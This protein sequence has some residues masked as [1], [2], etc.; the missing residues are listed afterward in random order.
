M[1]R[2]RLQLI[3]V[4]LALVAIAAL[5]LSQQPALQAVV[6]PPEPATGGV[7]A[8]GLIGSAGRFNP[9]LDIYNPVDRDVNRL[10]F[11]GLIRYDDRGIAQPDL[12]ESWGMSR[13]GTVYNFALRQNARWHDGTPVTSQ[14]IIFTIELMRDENFPLPGDIREIWNKVEVRLL[15]EHT[16]Q[17]R[18]PEP[19]APFLD[20]LTF[21]VLPYHLLGELTPAEIVNDPFNLNPV[22]TG[23][24]SFDSLIVEEGEIKGVILQAFGDYYQ[25]RAFLDEFIFRYYPDARAALAAY[26]AGEITGISQLPPEVLEQAL[27]LPEL[28]IYSSRLPELSLIL[29]NLD[30][31]SAPFLQEVE[32]RRALY[33]ALNR[34]Y[35]IDNILNGQAILATGPIYP[36]T[37]AVYEGQ[38]E[39]P[40]QPEEAV[41][42][43]R[44]TEY[45]IPV[46]GGSV[47]Q[48]EGQALSFEL[49]HP[50]TPF[51]TALA[52]AIQGYWQE[53]GVQV[54]LEAV[55]YDQLV[56]NYLEPR[57]Y[58]A[59]LV[60]FTT[61]NSP[62]PDPY[63]FWH[64]AQTP[65]GQNYSNWNDRQASE[66][67][68]AARVAVDFEER[69]RLYRNF[70]VRFS[71]ELPALPLFY[72]VYSFGVDN[73]V[74]GVRTGPLFDMS[75][76]FAH[77]TEWYLFVEQPGDGQTTGEIATPA[78]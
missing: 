17:I 77:V 8:E 32:V 21:G 12:A 50:D 20:L 19:Y 58:Q 65:N 14:D 71:Q 72:P 5:L 56:D 70:Q 26:E 6:A 76:R 35:M 73:Q 27:K 18:L 36:G 57:T 7:Y 9:L 46:E 22:G 38:V 66:Y 45:T 62:D 23:P 55:S 16:L 68:E 29:F 60:D 31:E 63:P 49:V 47:R 67:L 48:K 2:L 10:L 53:I 13:D 44:S 59:A 33:M 41:N 74:Q 43:L 25:A 69:L 54:T 61:A 15:D 11:S 52:E 37:W 30:Q 39:I 78:P 24:Y 28:G 4:L 51:H 75:D 1:K 40:Y 34:Q 64:Q 42:L 3:I